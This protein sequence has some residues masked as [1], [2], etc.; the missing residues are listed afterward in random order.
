MIPLTE[1]TDIKTTEMVKER[2]TGAIF[3]A[4]CGNSLAGSCIGLNHKD[5]LA[6][7][8]SALKEFI[9]GLSRSARP[10]HKPG[11]VL[12]DGHM[13]IVLGETL[14]K[15]KGKF[16]QEELQKSYKELLELDEFLRSGPGALCLAALRR[17]VDGLP[18]SSDQLEA[19][20]PSGA[21]RAVLAGCLPGKPKTDDPYHV[22]VEQ[23]KL[24]H[25]DTRVAAAAAVLAD[26]VH[27]F[28]SGEKLDTAEAVRAY[29]K[30]EFELS[31][32][33]DERFS[34][35]WD[36]VAPDLDYQNPA[37]ELPYSL[38]N[39][40]SEVTE[41]VPTAVGIFLIFRHNPKEAIR[42]A[43]RCGG[44]TDTV[45][46]VVG[47]LAG[48]YHGVKALPSEWT[49]NICHKERLETLANNLFGLWP[50]T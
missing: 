2:L 30:R 24:T 48:A 40:Q 1:K 33:I 28:I 41:L 21:V 26:S 11:E 20:H 45:G 10:D 5:I 35:A 19:L 44:D 15:S 14:V 46:I 39:V 42:A 3:G 16:S 22:A 25:N 6:T 34:E 50:Q 4:L 38:I 43:A 12:A 32:A 9:P 23:A 31:T 37:D 17:M 47:A 7:A 13:A 18:P 36:D 29:V 27:Y 8:G 49:A